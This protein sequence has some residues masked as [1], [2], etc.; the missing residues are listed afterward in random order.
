[1]EVAVHHPVWMAFHMDHLDPED[2]KA[3][4]RWSARIGVVCFS[5]TLL[6]FAAIA[7]RISTSDPQA[8]GIVDFEAPV[9]N[10][11]TAIERVHR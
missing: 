2:R 11:W 4:A 7:I 8:G 10:A 9:L 5:L 1:M 6:L 3:V